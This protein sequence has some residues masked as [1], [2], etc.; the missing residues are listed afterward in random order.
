MTFYK[1]KY[2]SFKNYK[3][4]TVKLKN[5]RK[6]ISNFTDINYKSDQTDNKTS[7]YEVENSTEPYLSINSKLKKIEPNTNSK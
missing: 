2:S 7:V 6:K 5:K 3:Y 4:E 1:K